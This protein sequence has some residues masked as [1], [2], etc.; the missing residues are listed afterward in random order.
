MRVEVVRDPFILLDRRNWFIDVNFIG[1][2]GDV[3]DHFQ[4][5]TT[6]LINCRK[7]Y[8][9][10]YSLCSFSGTEENNG[11]AFIVNIQ[12]MEYRQ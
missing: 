8:G 12:I 6:N 5:G 2:V 3:D 7:Y 9:F 11:N 1:I 10:R 4:S